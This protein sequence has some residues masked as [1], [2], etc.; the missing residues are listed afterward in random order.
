MKKIEAIIK[1]FKIDEVK[2]ALEKIGVRGM[3]VIDAKGRGRQRGFTEMNTGVEYGDFLPKVKL[4]II[5]EDDL[6]D[7]AVKAIIK[8]TNTN[9]IGDGK[10]FV[11]NIETIT[12]IRTGETGSEAL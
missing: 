11:S 7:N 3:T 4:E 10:I 8:S 5:L 12:R 2:I 9:R 6:V 1:P